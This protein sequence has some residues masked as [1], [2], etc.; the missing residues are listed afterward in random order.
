MLTWSQDVF[1]EGKLYP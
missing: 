1:F